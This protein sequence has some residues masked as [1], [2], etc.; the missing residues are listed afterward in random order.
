MGF[1]L[2][3]LIALFGFFALEANAPGASPPRP[4]PGPGPRPPAPP[5]GGGYPSP[6]P[7]GTSFD[8]PPSGNPAID[9]EFQLAL[10]ALLSSY[11]RTGCPGLDQASVIRFQRALNA[12]YEAFGQTGPLTADGLYDQATDGYIHDMIGTSLA[13]CVPVQHAAPAMFQQQSY[14]QAYP[15]P[16]QAYPQPQ[17]AYPQPQQAYPQPQQ[18]YP[19]PQQAYPQPQQQQAQPQQQQQQAQPPPAPGTPET[20]TPVGQSYAQAPQPASFASTFYGAD[21]STLSPTAGRLSY[22]GRS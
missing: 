9:H 8:V 18:A 6:Q 15:Q 14:P 22:A 7:T 12:Y 4:G 3:P 17:Q 10:A 11:G 19:Q 5:G 13:S 2:I 1:L 20:A 16:Q 21:P